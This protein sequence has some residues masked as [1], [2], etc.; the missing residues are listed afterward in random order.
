[1]RVIFGHWKYIAKNLW[2]VLPFAIVPAVFL[3][4]SL[5]YSAISQFLRAFFT[6]QPRADFLEYLRVWSFVRFDTWVGAIYSVLAVA[7]C[8]IFMTLMLAFVEKHMRIGK[9]TISGVFAQLGTLTLSTLAVTLAYVILYEI[10]AVVLAALLFVVAQIRVTALVYVLICLFVAVGAYVLLYVAT[11][12]YLWLPCR[13]VTGF[14]TYDAFLYS[15]RLVLG[16]RF[17][18]ILSW[19]LSFAVLIVA[20]GGLA[21]LPAYVFHLVAILFFAALFLAFGVR[22]ETVY[23]MTDKL[24]REDILKSY[25]EL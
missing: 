20:V 25:R 11:F 7:T 10:W 16:V 24:D 18:L 8:A 3:S 19:L 17:K 23:F 22:M 21:F 1:M 13:Q 5:D 15:Y 2:Y 12:F 9:R 14:G 4:L 6:G